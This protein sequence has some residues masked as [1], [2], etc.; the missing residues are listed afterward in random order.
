MY[1]NVNIKYMNILYICAY[2]YTF[3]YIFATFE[4]HF[5]PSGGRTSLPRQTKI[6]S[7]PGNHHRQSGNRGPENDNKNVKSYFGQISD[8]SRFVNVYHIFIKFGCL[9]WIR[10][11][12]GIQNI[13]VKCQF[14]DFLYFSRFM[15]KCLLNVVVDKILY[16]YNISI[17]LPLRPLAIPPSWAE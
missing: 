14:R 5:C 9:G 13:L 1:V 11:G 8:Q 10:S 17:T 16:I 15:R 4:L 6:W 3:W 12:H 7:R 2:V